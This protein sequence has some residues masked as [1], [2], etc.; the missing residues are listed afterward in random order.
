MTYRFDGD[1]RPRWKGRAF[2]PAVIAA[3]YEEAL[4]LAPRTLR[5]VEDLL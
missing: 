5:G 1:G 2:S 4:A 3:K